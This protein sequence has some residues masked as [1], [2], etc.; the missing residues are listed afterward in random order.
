[1]QIALWTNY[2]GPGAHPVGADIDACLGLTDEL[3]ICEG[4][5]V[6]GQADLADV[7]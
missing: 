7:H 1:M 2:L 6:Q 3:G 5:W 4:S